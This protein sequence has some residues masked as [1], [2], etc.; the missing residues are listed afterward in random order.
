MTWGADAPMVDRPGPLLAGASVDARMVALMR[1]LLALSGLLIVYIDPTEPAR[2]VAITYLSLAAYCA[3]SIALYAGT[4]RRAFAGAPVR[5]LHWIDVLFFVYLVGL[6]QGTNSIFF[7]FFFFA[8]LVA[9][10]SRG[11]REGLAVTAA[12]VV[13][14]SV[15][16]VGVAHALPTFELDRALIRPVYLFLLGY[17]MSYWGGHEITLRGRLNLL[18]EVAGVANPRLGVDRALRQCLQRVLEF[19]DAAACILVRAQSGARGYVLYRVDA[20]PPRAAGAPEVLTEK[21]AHALLEFPASSAVAWNR[22]R[23]PA[24]PAL[25]E[26]CARLANLL[27]ASCFASVPYREEEGS[28]GR[29]FVV[30]RKRCI[31]EAEVEF[32]S[33]VIDQIAA[34]VQNL[35]LIDELMLNAAQLER[36]RI[37]RDIH[38]TTL[39]PYIGLKLGL[40]ALHRKFGADTPGAAQLKELLEMSALAVND[41]RGYVA[42]LR[43][44][45]QEWP[46]DHLVAGL[47]DQI[48]RYRSFYGIEVE[49]R[50]DT[51]VQLT[52]AIATESYQI[53]C[54]ALSNVCRHTRARRAYVELRCQAEALLIEVGNERNADAS[55]PPFMPRS[56]AERAAALGGRAEVVLDSAGYDIVR[57]AVPLR[58]GISFPRGGEA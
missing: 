40:E 12:S 8:I 58:G 18:R 33:Q 36:S 11:F 52:D 46:G 9:S 23:P 32:L 4:Y 3:Y 26:T 7:F 49:L 2:M 51:A 31:A 5:A 6:T 15:V 20:A 41:L 10:F 53:I 37:S 34:A 35:A 22:K 16:G 56:I 19:F 29:V 38:D 55:T 25:A 43:T 27:E 57:V 50:G 42:R 17:M 14:F 47:R 30:A 48:G 39:Q 28:V 13:L 54:E 44:N 1:C 24:D 45:Q 21:S